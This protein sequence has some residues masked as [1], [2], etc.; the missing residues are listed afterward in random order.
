MALKVG[1]IL[2][3]ARA[4]HP[5]TFRAWVENDLPFGLDTAKRL[6]AISEAYEKLPAA[7]LE[8]LPRPWQA[9]YA[10][11]ALP[12]GELQAAV[13]AG[14]VTAGISVGSAS[15]TGP[16]SNRPSTDST[17]CCGRSRSLP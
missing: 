2:R 9:L 6:M 12:L 7:T 16:R 4:E 8:Q 5:E 3:A 1:A 10:L 11:R 13:D 15:P 17:R 14:V